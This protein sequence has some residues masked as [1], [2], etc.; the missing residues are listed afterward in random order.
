MDT[1][2][3]SAEGTWL[4]EHLRLYFGLTEARARINQTLIAMLQ[5]R[6]YRSYPCLN[7]IFWTNRSMANFEIQVDDGTATVSLPLTNF[8]SLESHIAEAS[9]ELSKRFGTLLAPANDTPRESGAPL[10]DLPFVLTRSQLGGLIDWTV[11]LIELVDEPIGSLGPRQE[12]IEYMPHDEIVSIAESML[13]SADSYAVS[14]S[15]ISS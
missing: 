13:G 5:D 7:S 2:E 10:S 4:S 1:N 8:E 14:Q 6:I 15:D 11:Q 3:N 9:A 12:S